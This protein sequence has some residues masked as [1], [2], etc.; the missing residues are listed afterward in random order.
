M[1]EGKIVAS[2]ADLE[3][4]LD[5]MFAK[6]DLADKEIFSIYVGEEGSEEFAEQLQEKLE[7]QFEDLEVEIFP[8]DQPVYPYLFSAE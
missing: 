6:M 4:A 5:L 1:V 3:T 2:D 7:G 8:G